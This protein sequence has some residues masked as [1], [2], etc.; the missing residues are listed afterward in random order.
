MSDV[1][2]P[3]ICVFKSVITQNFLFIAH[4]YSMRFNS[5]KP[6]VIFMGIGK[7][8]RQRYDAAERGV[9]SGAILFAQTNF[10]ENSL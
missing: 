3:P 10:I 8:Y 4:A 6:G 2:E 1:Q 7:Q 9:P 5:Y